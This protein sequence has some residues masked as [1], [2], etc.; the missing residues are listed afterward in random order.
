MRRGGGC[1]PPGKGG[2][3]VG[4]NQRGRNRHQAGALGV[5]VAD[6]VGDYAHA[7]AR[8]VAAAQRRMAEEVP[9]ATVRCLLQQTLREAAQGGRGLQA[10]DRTGGRGGV[11][12]AVDITTALYL[13]RNPTFHA[14]IGDILRLTSRPAMRWGLGN[15]AFHA[16]VR[17]LL[18]AIR[19][20]LEVW[21]KADILAAADLQKHHKAVVDIG[22]LWTALGWSVT[23]WVH[24]TTTGQTRRPGGRGTCTVQACPPMQYEGRAFR[25]K[26]EPPPPSALW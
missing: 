6:R 8:I 13:I 2:S 7:I 10:V 21:S 23:P 4:G 16:A 24:W 19:S 5:P 9:E 26:A 17:M 15:L 3:R 1:I 20:L 25:M 14:R 11:H 12:P 18:G 22:Q